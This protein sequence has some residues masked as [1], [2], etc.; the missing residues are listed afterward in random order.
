MSETKGSHDW[1]Q[2]LLVGRAVPVP[3]FRKHEI[4]ANGSL[5][6]QLRYSDP[7][8]QVLQIIYNLCQI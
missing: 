1:S 8:A 4:S 5:T 7:P 2:M 6:P 3:L